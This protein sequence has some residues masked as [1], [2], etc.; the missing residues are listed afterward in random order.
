MGVQSKEINEKLIRS[1]LRHK[2]WPQNSTPPQSLWLSLLWVLK[3]VETL[4]TLAV[5]GLTEGKKTSTCTL[6]FK[7]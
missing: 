2:S 5:N 3:S 7:R 4:Q 6:G 1:N